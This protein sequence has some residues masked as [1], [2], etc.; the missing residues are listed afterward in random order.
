MAAAA[1]FVLLAGLTLLIILTL[2]QGFD[3][4]N[5]ILIFVPFLLTGLLLLAAGAFIK[6]DIVKLFLDSI[7]SMGGKQSG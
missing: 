6:A 7:S 1:V 4:T 5:A 3:A 2:K